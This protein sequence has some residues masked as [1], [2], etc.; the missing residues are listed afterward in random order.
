MTDTH[1]RPYLRGITPYLIFLVVTVTLGPLQFGFH[2]AELNAPHDAITCKNRQEKPSDFL[3]QWLPEC[4]PMSESEFAF[5]SSIFTLGGL[6]GAL[7][8]GPVSTRFGILISMRIATL[9]SL[10]GASHEALA[11]HV[12]MLVL[13]R[14]LAGV[15]AG[16]SLVVVPLYVS[17]VAPPQS[18]GSF[19]AAT[20]IAVNLGILLT[21]VSGYIFGQDSE[22]RIALAVGAGFAVLQ[23]VLLCAVSESPAWT[24]T[25]RDPELALS[26]LKRIRGTGID[27]AEEIRNW[28]VGTPKTIADELD[29]LLF[30]EESIRYGAMSPSTHK[31]TTKQVGFLEVAGSPQ[32]R[33]AL[34]AV[35]GVMMAQQLT[36]INSVM[37]YSVELM[38][39]IFPTTSTLL[40]IMLSLINLLTTILC[41]PLPDKLGRKPALLLSITGMGFSSLALAFSMLF[42]IKILSAVSAICFVASFGVGIGAIPF[43]LAS[44]LV[45]QEASSATQGWGLAANWIATFSIAQFCP[46]INDALN[47]KFGGTGWVYFIFTALALISA[48]FVV[49]CVPET[50]K[51][52]HVEEPW[53]RT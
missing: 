1:A 19:G 4:L 53:E 49:C 34:I 21:L 5:V 35:V 14:L 29:S 7:S 10:I 31:E 11:S 25:N 17:E 40:T 50:Q 20:Q 15:G 33:P 16:I 27:L 48:I 18:K 23:G 12:S 37:M 26:I 39:S 30:E 24:A 51:T 6:L 36:G 45:D 52:G 44:E 47:S 13:G 9:A 28:N 42:S 46:M 8:A 43:I 3:L 2:L 22:W 32:Y 38:S 41:A